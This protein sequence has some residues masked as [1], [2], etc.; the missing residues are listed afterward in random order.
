MLRPV[1]LRTDL[2]PLADLIELVFADTMDASGR[3]ALREMRM[4]SRMGAALSFF[5][6]LNEMAVGIGMGVV[7]ME[8]GQLVGN[9]SVYPAHLPRGAGDGWIIANV[10]VHPNFQRRGIAKKLMTAALD[11]IRSKGG[12]LALL[13]VDDDNTPA[14]D[15]YT[16]LGF[17][18]ERAFTTYKRLPSLRLPALEHEGMAYVRRRRR[19]EWRDE[20]A[21]AAALRPNAQG[22]VGWLRPV[23]PAMFQPDILR[24]LSDMVNFRNLDRYVAVDE[25]DGLRAALWID[26]TFG[27]TNRLTLINPPADGD[28]YTEALLAMAV[29]QFG[30]GSLILE[31]PADDSS[32]QTML[33][34]FK[35]NPQRTVIHMRWSPNI[36]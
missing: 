25:H 20:M 22:G 21:L 14:I 16:H 31:H 26:R 13:Q 2:A 17:V 7:W 8:G 32:I 18:T 6:K 1:N 23:I 15:L 4:M 3:A 33:S 27:L 35:F 9:V 10:G 29:H 36:S 34:R 30:S 19:P 11:T 28:A 12:K 5:A 24:F